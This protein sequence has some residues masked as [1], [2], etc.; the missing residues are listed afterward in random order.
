MYL[1]IRYALALLL[2][3]SFLIAQETNAPRERV[4]SVRKAVDA[5]GKVQQKELSI[6][7]NFKH[8]F[9]DGKVSG[10]LRLAYGSYNYKEAFSENTYAT[11]L[12]GILK[13]EL[14]Q[15][16]GFNAAVAMYAS[17]DIIPLTGKGKKYNSDFSS[18][19]GSYTELG[20]AY[21]NYQYN[22]FNVRIGR[23]T[24]D[25]P[26][27]D[28]D[29]VRMIQ[30]SFNA[31]VMSYDYNGISI[32]AGNIQSWQG[33]DA[34]LDDGWVN[35]GDKGVNF[36]GLSYNNA[37][38]FSS[39][40]Y[41]M[42]DYTNAFYCEGGFTYPLE[43]QISLH[44]MLQYLHES[45]LKQ[46]GYGAN[47]YGGSIELVFDGLGL[48]FAY[49]KADR[50]KDQEAFSGTGGGTLFTSMDTMTLDLLTKNREADAY[51]SGIS[52]DFNHYS[53]LYA[54]GD[55]KAK[56]NAQEQAAEVVEQDISFEYHV[57][58]SFLLAAVYVNSADKA[59]IQKSEYDFNR[60]QIMM[61]Y[62]F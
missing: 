24:L 20:E 56:A 51:V 34:G 21:L 60:L 27:A 6:V 8:M 52:Y 32:I 40:Y 28:S 23:Q 43:K 1:T 17:H 41:N 45:Q 19:K 33:F 25:T 22:D 58:E 57:N 31:A 35:I 4:H 3:E 49:N 44:T 2:L 46:S 38:E 12:G 5:V 55:F 39:W 54:Y 18:S 26:L 61:N 10:Q 47:I 50:K 53:V 16:N 14:A 48:N 36:A 9:Q 37:V 29:D 7:D 13:Y 30:N 15:Y 59:S 42:P 62:N 11:A